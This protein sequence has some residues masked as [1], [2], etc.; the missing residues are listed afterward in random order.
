MWT[1]TGGEGQQRYEGQRN[2]WPLLH[3]HLALLLMLSP[4][5]MTTPEQNASILGILAPVKLVLQ[6]QRLRGQAGQAEGGMEGQLGRGRLL[7]GRLVP[8]WRRQRVGEAGRQQQR[9]QNHRRLPHTH[10]VAHL[11]ACEGGADAQVDLLQGG[12]GGT[13]GY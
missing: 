7:P 9:V 5:A 13:E 4:P 6:Q 2:R 10:T 1:G 8:A 12:E 11:Q 3:A